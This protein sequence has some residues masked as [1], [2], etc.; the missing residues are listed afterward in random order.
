MIRDQF[1]IST[2]LCVGA[3][4][5]IF[6][7]LFVSRSL[8]LYAPVLLLAFRFVDTML[9]TFGLTRNRQMDG[10]ILKKFS[11]QLPDED[12]KFSDNVADQPVTVILLGARS[13]Q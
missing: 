6:A 11:A 9:M 12:G 2:W 1:S 8:A 3:T 4:L 13:N 10:I 7:W 5:Q